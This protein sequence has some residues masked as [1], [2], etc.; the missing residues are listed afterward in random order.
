MYGFNDERGWEKKCAYS[1]TDKA[2]DY[3]PKNAGSIP[4][5]HT[6]LKI[7]SEYRVKKI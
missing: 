4:A 2:L 3:E 6:A 5:K 1:L 7:N